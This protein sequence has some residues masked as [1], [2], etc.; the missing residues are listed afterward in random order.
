[1]PPLAGIHPTYIAGVDVTRLQKIVKLG[2]KFTGV[3][4]PDGSVFIV[5]PVLLLGKPV[6]LVS[7]GLRDKIDIEACLLENKEGMKS[8]GDEQA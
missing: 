4:L 2:P 5:K 1:V 8:F 7:S 6:G 3:I